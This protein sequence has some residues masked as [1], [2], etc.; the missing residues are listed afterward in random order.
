MVSQGS[1]SFFN[2]DVVYG[3]PQILKNIH[4]KVTIFNSRRSVGNSTLTSLID[5]HACLVRYIPSFVLS[6]HAR[7]LETSEYFDY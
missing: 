3:R 5:E 1:I 4:R 6:E 2:G 7:L